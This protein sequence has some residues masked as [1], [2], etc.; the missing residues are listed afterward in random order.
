MLG[1]V[2]AAAG[3]AGICAILVGEAPDVRVR[4]LKDRLP[5]A[6]LVEGDRTFAHW[7]AKVIGFVDAPG[8]GLDPPSTQ[9]APR[10]SSA[11]GER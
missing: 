4:D 3:Q 6:N 5:R 11:C 1:A 10:S 7:M 9:A 2:V 8:A